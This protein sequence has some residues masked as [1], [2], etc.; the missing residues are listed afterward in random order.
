MKKILLLFFLSFFVFFP[1]YAYA[2]GNLVINEFLAHPSTGN[3]EW[4][5]F[6][7]P[8]AIDISH[9]WIDDDDSFTDDKGSASKRS[10]ESLNTSNSSYPYIE[11]SSF[12]N[13]DGD[14]VVL[15]DDS[16][17]IVD[18]FHYDKDPGVDVPIGRFP[19]GTGSF[20]ML[21]SAT[22]GD[23]NV[24]P[25]P[26]ATPTQFLTPTPKNTSTPT[27]EP[28]PTR[29]PTLTKS[30]TPTKV[31]PIKV[32]ENFAPISLAKSETIPTYSAGSP[33]GI[34]GE[35][36]LSASLD[37]KDTPLRKKAKAVLVKSISNNSSGSLGIIAIGVA[38][39]FIGCG[40][41]VF[42]KVKSRSKN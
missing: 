1:T 37:K 8:D 32:V 25:L 23:A 21:A 33:S 13:N 5:E 27:K 39:I 38:V 24:G 12:L 6:F 36:S 35:S 11:L 7:N 22:I 42:L 34:L 9:Y 10:L 40:I 29:I 19:D 41:L 26:T 2:D 16:D 14:K 4:V 17:T 20:Q 31:T 30:P 18:Q 15:F 28:T 3:K